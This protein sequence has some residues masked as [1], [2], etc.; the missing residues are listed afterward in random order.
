MLMEALDKWKCDKNMFGCE[1]DEDLFGIFVQEYFVGK[2]WVEMFAALAYQTYELQ[3]CMEG[4]LEDVELLNGQV[5][6]KR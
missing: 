5:N 4:L 2:S 6:Q 1:I 3:V